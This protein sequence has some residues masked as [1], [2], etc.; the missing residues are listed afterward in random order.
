MLT[1]ETT[2]HQ[3]RVLTAAG[4][5]NK[6]YLVEGTLTA[7]ANELTILPE[8]AKY[9][10]L[11][12]G[13]ILEI[14]GGTYTITGL[15]YYPAYIYP[16]VTSN[17]VKESSVYYPETQSVVFMTEEGLDNL[18]GQPS[19]SYK[20]KANQ[21]LTKDEKNVLYH[22]L[23]D[24]NNFDILDNAGDSVAHGEVYV[25]VAG[26]SATIVIL[27]I[28]LCSSCMFVVALIIKRRIDADK[29]QIGVLKALGYKSWEIAGSYCAFTVIIS[30]LGSAVGCVMGHLLYKPIIDVLY[31]DYNLPIRISTNYLTFVYAF[32]VPLI[33]LVS[34]SLITALLNLR[35]PPLDLIWDNRESNV[36]A[37]GKLATR[38]F[39]K[40]SFETRTKYQIA[41][42]S[43]PKLAAM[44]FVG[45]IASSMLLVGLV[46]SSAFGGIV[47]KT[48]SGVTADNVVEFKA[49]ANINDRQPQ[50][51]D[52]EIVLAK[53]LFIQEVRYQNG[54]TLSLD[55]TNKIQ[56]E[57]LGLK[58]DSAYAKLANEKGDI[59]NSA[60]N[61]V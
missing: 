4:S 38:I 52:E 29:K 15:A 44:L 56:A 2:G 10:N 24:T 47:D 12:A 21:K 9:N 1:N 26:I 32:A 35:K 40:T 19:Y 54:E 25:R 3:Y 59:K 23:Y 49:I 46:M 33:L 28:V 22:R 50:Y 13:D 48:F 30:L 41:C 37:L 57:T 18:A 5:I 6:P 58:L 42:R 39:R 17:V 51:A 43:M 14:N 16:I 36:N 11:Q 53:D 7:A 31:K 60:G 61:K 20:S 34:I 27:A 55:D 8:Y 45:F